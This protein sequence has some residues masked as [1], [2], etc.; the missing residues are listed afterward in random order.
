MGLIIANQSSLQWKITMQEWHLCWPPY[1]F[2]WP[3]SAAHFCHSR[4]ATVAP[5]SHPLTGLTHICPSCWTI[6]RSFEI[7]L[8]MG[9]VHWIESQ[10]QCSIQIH[11]FKKTFMPIWIMFQK[12]LSC[13]GQ[14]GLQWMSPS[15]ARANEVVR[16]PTTNDI[17]LFRSPVTGTRKARHGTKIY[18]EWQ[19]PKKRARVNNLVK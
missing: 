4:I 5:V 12:M 7:T 2:P 16:T 14:L 15:K 13:I 10:I 1:L 17:V 18:E 3:L 9:A 11:S 19:G 8:E 6:Y